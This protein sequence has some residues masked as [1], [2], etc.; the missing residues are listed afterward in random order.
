M[1][2]ELNKR[3]LSSI[4]FL[5]IILY[6]I[7]EGSFYFVFLIFTCFVISI[8]E[9]QKMI[10][11]FHIKFIG[12]FF[13]IL[14]FYTI[15]QFRFIFNNNY[16]PFLILFICISTDIGGFIWKLFKGPKLTKISPNK[17]YSGMIGGYVLSI[18]GYY[19]L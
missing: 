5:P 1:N 14:S 2:S 11:N 17:T 16:Y 15:F 13:L 19:F 6:V 12:I 10:K 18:L 3:V 7:I 9:W 4:I 8:Y